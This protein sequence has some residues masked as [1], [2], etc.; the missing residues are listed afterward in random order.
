MIPESKPYLR[1]Q[2]AVFQM[3]REYYYPY[4]TQAL[5]TLFYALEI[6]VLQVTSIYPC[7]MYLLSVYIGQLLWV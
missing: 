2:E 4:P 7:N 6:S 1:K 5:I 3:R